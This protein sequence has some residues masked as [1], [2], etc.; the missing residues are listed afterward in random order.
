[1]ERIAPFLCL[2]LLGLGCHEPVP[3]TERPAP[4][5]P[6][7]P[8]PPARTP[9]AP[10]PT[11]DLTERLALFLPKS[12]A[13][14]TGP[15]TAGAGFVRRAYVDRERIRIDVTIAGG[16]LGTEAAYQDWLRMSAAYPQ[17]RL[18]VAPEKGSG[19]YTCAPGGGPGAPEACDLH[20]QLLNG[21]HVEVMGGGQASRAHLDRL[22]RELPLRA[23]ADSG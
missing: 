14:E 1:M 20:I 21:L 10:A 19:F 4:V 18:D 2:A 23:M 17:A 8:R 6:E 12:E 22:L 16:V 5:D 3:S 11:P 15:T 13:Y 7:V 9:R